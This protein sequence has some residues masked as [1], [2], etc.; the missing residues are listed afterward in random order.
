MNSEDK[1]LD[2]DVSLGDGRADT[3][4]TVLCPYCGEANDIGLDPGG[5]SRQEYSEDCQVCCRPWQ[6]VVSFDAYGEATL[7]LEAADGG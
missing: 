7:H 2:D 6:I 3:E 1:D 5:G 4:A